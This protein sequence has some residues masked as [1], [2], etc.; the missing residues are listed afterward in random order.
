MN[1]SKSISVPITTTLEQSLP[2]TSDGKHPPLICEV[3]SGGICRILAGMLEFHRILT[4]SIWLEPQPFWFSIPWKFQWNLGASGNGFHWNP[5]EFHLDSN[6]KF[7]SEDVLYFKSLPLHTV[8]T[9]HMSTHGTYDT[10]HAP[11]SLYST[12]ALAIVKY[13]ECNS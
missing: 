10:S 2:P 5:L 3:S 4:E 11:P 13:P 9:V 7:N 12:H 1:L 8:H 6:G